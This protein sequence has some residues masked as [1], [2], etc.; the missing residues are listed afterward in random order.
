MNRVNLKRRML[1]HPPSRLRITTTF[2]SG[3]INLNSKNMKCFANHAR[4]SLLKAMLIMKFTTLLLLAFALQVSAN[5][6]TQTRVSLKLKKTSI[7]NVLAAI[8]G[9]TTYRFLYNQDLSAINTR[10]SISVENAEVKDVLDQ[11]LDN[12]SL[13]YQFMQNNLVVIRTGTQTEAANP[14]ITVTGNVMSNTGEILSGVSVYQKGTNNGT[15]TDGSG[16]YSISVPENATLVF[17]SVGY[18]TVEEA[19]NS[20]TTISV[21]LQSSAQTIQ[22]VVVVGYGTQRKIDVTGSVANIRGEEIAKQPSGNPVSSL[23]GKVA[24]VQIV[25]TGAPG[26]SP[27]IRIRGV[28]TLYGNQNP[29]YVVDGVWYDDI[30]FL[31]PQDIENLSILKDASSESIYGIRAANGVVL[32]TTKKGKRGQSNVTYNAFVGWQ[33]VTNQIDMAN[34][35]EYA[36][37]INELRGNTLLNP[38][39]FGEGTDWYGLILRNALVH[40]HQVGMSGGSERSTYNFSL[41]YYNQEGIVET[42]KYERF[43]AR[44]QNDF[45]VFKP[46]KVGYTLTGVASRSNDIPGSIFRELYAAPTIVPA[47]YADGSYGD[48]SDFDLGD[49]A[50]FNPQATLDF[51]NQKSK[52]F[53]GTGNV[54][55]DLNFARDFTFRTSLGGDFGQ[56]EYRHYLPEYTA[57]LKQRNTLSSLTVGR[58]ETRNWI[59]ENTLTYDKRIQDHNVRLLVG[60]SAQENKFYQITGNAKGV[61]FETEDDLFLTLGNTGTNT[62][63]DGGDKERFSSYFGRINY[64]FNNKYLLNASLRA[65]GASKF[66]GDKRWGYFP[67]VGIGWIISD[68]AFMGD[69]EIFDALK[70][71]ASW[72]VVGNAKVP[73]N[74]PFVVINNGAGY[75]VQFGNTLVTGA[76]ITQQTPPA[77]YWEK[78]EGID[79]GLEGALMDN[80]LTFEFDYYNRETKDAIFSVPILGSLGTSSGDITANQASI[81]NKGFEISLG[82][83]DDL[84]SN[85]NYRING[86]I[87]IN[88]NEVSETKTGDNP[89]FGGGGAATGGQLATRTIVGQPIGQYYG[90]QVAGIFQNAAQVAGSPQSATAKPGDFIFVDQNK[91]GIIDGKDRVVLGDPNARVTYGLNTNWNYKKLDLT[92]DFQGVSGVDIYNANMGLRFGTENFTKDFFDNRWHG[93]G[94][95]NSYPSVNIG[96]GDNYRP[97]SFFV[98]DGSYFRIRNIQLGYTFAPSIGNVNIKQL[99]VY[100]NAQNAFNFF[101]YRGF[102]P[103]IGGNALNRGIDSNVYPMYAT[104]NF[105]VNV[106]F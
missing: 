30:S 49:G 65:D 7:S 23:Q 83:R 91:D 45:Q 2:I 52:N 85:L 5:G 31:N 47:F 12:T 90:L 28:G 94:T 79:I 78:A 98:E 51:F 19:V 57:T 87:G 70:L 55:A 37:L 96:G 88:D 16:N 22:E 69:Q 6:F 80:R 40:N 50:N 18:L 20:R 103:E 106:T 77:I 46:L 44:L 67:S 56:A 61:P 33:S 8:E 24:G 102:S 104:Y 39:Q 43:T 34:G 59:F 11:V 54:F 68:E 32:I 13:S 9:Q 99:R 72:G 17:S 101:E 82:W 64:S 53:R 25:N 81:V 95:S 62:V 48:P 26:S 1:Q 60:Q 35:A 29:L 71:R 58:T 66:S 41:G 14:F 3:L 63:V 75:S 36:T 100:A 105:G 76:S 92:L 74:L 38:A 27:Q 21:V 42:N 97:N 10:V 15:T 89:V 84:N 93:D 73:S 4:T 86:N